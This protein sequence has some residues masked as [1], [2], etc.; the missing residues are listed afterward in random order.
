MATNVKAGSG[1]WAKWR[2]NALVQLAVMAACLFAWLIAFQGFALPAIRKLGEPGT[3]VGDGARILSALVYIAGAITLY[4]LMV[5]WIERRPVVELA[6]RPGLSLAVTGFAIGTLLFSSVIAVIW[7]SGGVE[8]ATPGGTTHL[9]ASMAAAA[10]AAVVEE[11]LFRGVLFRI[12]ERAT[13]TLIALVVSALLF[14]LAH[15]ANP[16]ATIVSVVA[17]AIEAGLL[18]GIAYVASRNLWFP[19]GIHFAWNFTQGGIFGVSSSGP[20]QHG[21]LSMEFSGSN[22]MTGGSFGAESS[23]ISILLCLAVAVLFLRWARQKGE[24]VPPRLMLYLD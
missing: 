1:G 13:G 12:V 14:G 22:L 7:L 5:G 8:S 2:H 11:L 23:V 20:T 9:I 18:L 6:R 4:R 17:I 10:M 3:F 24:W 19:I 21:L 15:L 16:D